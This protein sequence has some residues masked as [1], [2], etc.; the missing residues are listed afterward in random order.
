MLIF[1]VALWVRNTQLIRILTIASVVCWIPYD[2]ITLA[3]GHL[4]IKSIELASAV[5]G[6]VKYKRLQEVAP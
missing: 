1:T 4:I 2:L 5:V 3:F 6:M